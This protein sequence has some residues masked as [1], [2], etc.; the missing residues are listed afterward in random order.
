MP[1][2]PPPTQWKLLP[3]AGV[4]VSM[5][6]AVAGNTFETEQ[7]LTQVSPGGVAVVI[8]PLPLPAGRDVE[9]V[10]GHELRA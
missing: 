7:L 5:T 4:G 3:T 1:E 2:Q 8:F 10:R 6:T 9:R